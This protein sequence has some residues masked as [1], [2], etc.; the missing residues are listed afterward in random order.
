MNNIDLVQEITLQAYAFGLYDLLQNSRDISRGEVFSIFREWAREFENEHIGFD[1][2]ISPYY[3]EIDNFLMH[4]KHVLSPLHKVGEYVGFNSK[5]VYRIIKI[6]DNGY[7]AKTL[8]D[9]VFNFSFTDDEDL[10]VF[11][12]FVEIMDVYNA[13]NPKLVAAINAAWNNINK[14]DYFGVILRALYC[15][16]ADEILFSDAFSFPESADTDEVER[17]L[18]KDWE[19]HA[20]NYLMHIADDADLEC[21]L[22]FLHSDYELA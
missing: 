20:Y 6:T 11:P 4:K 14:H 5:E 9:K 17:I 15:R 19:N 3:D 12:D 18:C 2:T 7:V 13:H 1:W 22:N 8:D 21:I 10:E 16:D